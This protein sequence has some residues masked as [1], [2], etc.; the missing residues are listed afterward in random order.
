MDVRLIGW[1]YK[2]IRGGLD[3]LQIDLGNP[4][5]HWTLIQMPNGMGK[6]TTMQLLRAAFS[7]MQLDEGIVRD[8]RSSDLG[9]VKK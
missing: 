9:S 7:G 8:F 3:G 4:P 2:N 6:T 1:R 5:S